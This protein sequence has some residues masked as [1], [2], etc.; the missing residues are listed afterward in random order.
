MVDFSVLKAPNYLELY[1]KSFDT[2]KARAREDGVQNVLKTS[3]GDLVGAEKDLIAMGAFDEASKL[4]TVR[5]DQARQRAANAAKAL[6]FDEAA[7]AMSEVGDV[8]AAQAF[9]Q[10]GRTRATGAKVAAGDLAGART[11]A[12]SAGD[13]DVA[14]EIGKLSDAERTQA[15]EQAET[16]AAIAERLR[17]S[18]PYEKR[19]ETIRSIAPA[20]AQRGIEREDL[21]ALLDADLNDAT[22]E[23]L[24]AS[25]SG[26]KEEFARSKPI[27]VGDG[28]VVFDPVSRKPIFEN[29]KNFAP[30]APKAGDAVSTSP[31]MEAIGAEIARRRAAGE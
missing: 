10:Q 31:L 3:M 30:R 25:A 12:L 29:R 24:I 28:G 14:S 6:R 7:T 19:A 23:A 26:L 22:L 11:D 15:A 17:T 9:A 1:Q 2:G 16:L 18:V 5:L 13:F 27:S 4:R 21:A 20:L 8:Q